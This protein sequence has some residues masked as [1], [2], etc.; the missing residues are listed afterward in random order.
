MESIVLLFPCA[1]IFREKVPVFKSSNQKS[2]KPSVLAVVATNTF[3]YINNEGLHLFHAY[4]YPGIEDEP[5]SRVIL[6]LSSP[7]FASLYARE[8]VSC[9][10]VAFPHIL[11]RTSW[12]L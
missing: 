10:Y 7:N 3:G 5:G 1:S 6:S 4:F 2:P 12:F 11:S 8:K 9:D